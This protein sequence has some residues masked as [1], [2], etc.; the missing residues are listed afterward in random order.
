[1]LLTVREALMSFKRAP[2]L[3]ALSIMMIAFSLFSFG[4]FALVAIN[5][6]QELGR[7]EERVQ[8][9]A[10]VDDS[11]SVTTL[12]DAVGLAARYPE[13]QRAAPITREEA[14]ARARE[15]MPEFQDVFDAE[16]LPASIEV[17][18]KEGFRDAASVKRV[19]D[20]LSEM[21]YVNDV[22]YGEE[23][24]QQLDAIR[25]VATGTGIALGTAFALVAII[26]IAATIRIT[27]L[28]RAREIS[29]MRLV[30]ATDGFVRRPFLLEGLLT[31]VAGGLFALLLLRG[32]HALVTRLEFVN[33]L[34][35]DMNMALAGIAA[36]GLLG[37]LGSA[38][39][40]RRHLRQV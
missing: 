16:F 12:T 1:M 36:G 10:F 22:R 27:V 28:A 30:G 4:L 2:L 31:G 35:L 7:V 25:T 39:A 18:M 34:F 13:V 38:F 3:S 6:R 26:I 21:P 8:L 11:T 5:F 19:A 15:V 29:I 23:F 37:F 17:Q 20:R 33:A 32:A 40:V 14:L 9:Q 24:V